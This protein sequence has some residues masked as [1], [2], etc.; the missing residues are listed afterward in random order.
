MI[1]IPFLEIERN[2]AGKNT[3]NQLVRMQEALELIITDYS[4]HHPN[5]SLREIVIT[6]GSVSLK[7]DFKKHLEFVRFKD[8]TPINLYF[9][10][11]EIIKD[12][13]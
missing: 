1:Y 9:K 7:Y 3:D 5:L 2:K 8:E 12:N 4:E 6:N 11:D 13:L 10:G